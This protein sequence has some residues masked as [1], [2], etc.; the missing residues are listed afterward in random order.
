[1]F[2]T[3]FAISLPSAFKINF[4]RMKYESKATQL[5]ND[6]IQEE[7][8]FLKSQI[9][10][11]FL[12]NSLNTVYNLIDS[13]TEEA[14]N[15]LVKFSEILRYALY[16]ASQDTISL[17]KE[18]EYIKG[19]AAIEKMRKG[20]SLE[21]RLNENI[22]GFFEVPPMMLLTFVENAFKH[23]SNYQTG[24]YIE[25]NLEV[26]NTTLELVVVNSKD[27]FK[28]NNGLLANVGGIGLENIKRRLELIYPSK[29]DLSFNETEAFY[30]VKL[31]LFTDEQ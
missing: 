16:E 27:S 14:K 17:H 21:V 6:K 8:K 19:Y 1:M 25:I 13:D 11:H 18:F 28:R 5:L 12:F 10:P 2:L 31:K 30:E 15:T 23:V 7:L 22:K 24:N 29:H 26:T 3:A 9:N 20:K 4:D